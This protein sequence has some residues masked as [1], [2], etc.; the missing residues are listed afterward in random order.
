MAVERRQVQRRP[1]AVVRVDVDAVLQQR[2]YRVGLTVP[3]K[4]YFVENVLV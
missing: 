4:Q 2:A 1:A 3:V